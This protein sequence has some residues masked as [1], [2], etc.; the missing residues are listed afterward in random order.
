MSKVYGLLLLA[1]IATAASEDVQVFF[2]ACDWVNRRA[3]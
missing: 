3:Q 2:A 1:G